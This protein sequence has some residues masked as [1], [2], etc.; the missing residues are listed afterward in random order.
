MD[1]PKSKEHIGAVGVLPI[2]TV[3][4]PKLTPRSDPDT[5]LGFDFMTLIA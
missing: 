2:F 1:L 4:N 3:F 5:T